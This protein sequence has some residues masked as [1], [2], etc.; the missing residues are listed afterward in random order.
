MSL[1]LEKGPYIFNVNNLFV[2][3]SRSNRAKRMLLEL[4]NGLVALGGSG[5][6]W[7]VVAS[8]NASSVKNKGDGSPDLWIT[9]SNISYGNPGTAHSWCILENLTT[10]GELLIDYNNITYP[11]ELRA[12]V[13]YSP[14]GTFTDTGTV[15]NAPTASDYTTMISRNNQMS[16][17]NTDYKFVL[18]IMTSADHHIT[19]WYWHER[20]NTSGSSGGM[21]GFIEEAQDTPAEWNSSIKA[22]MFYYPSSMAESTVPTDKSP[23]LAA[24]DGSSIRVRYETAEPYAGTLGCY[25]SCQ[26]YNWF[27]RFHT[28]PLI[29]LNSNLTLLG[30]YPACPIG[31]FRDSN[32][33]GGQLGRLADLYFAPYNHDT[34]DTYPDDA[35]RL[36]VKWGCFLVP[37]NGTQPVDAI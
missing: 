3:S 29:K 28:Q 23:N 11:A 27:E 34:F 8:S 37:W 16:S 12:D 1:T 4:K 26:G 2:E 21:I 6:I 17:M 19:R 10:G 24:I 33:K 31:I 13:L 22:T 36:W 25:P 30:G 18:N 7:N 9:I 32:P 5:T 35:S 14:G 20:I 15:T